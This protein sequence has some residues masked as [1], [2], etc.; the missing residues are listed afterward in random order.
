MSDT[1][2]ILLSHHLKALKLLTLPHPMP[3]QMDTALLGR[4]FRTAA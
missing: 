2:E 1:P 3:L 4:L